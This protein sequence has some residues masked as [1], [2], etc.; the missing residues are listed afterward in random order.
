MRVFC[1]SCLFL[2]VVL[3]FASCMSPAEK[4]EKALHDAFLPI[5]FTDIHLVNTE[6]NTFEGTM[7]FVATESNIENILKLYDENKEAFALYELL[8]DGSDKVI[9]EFVFNLGIFFDPDIPI[10]FWDS[11]KDMGDTLDCEVCIVY[12]GR[13][14][15]FRKLK[16]NTDIYTMRWLFGEHNED[17][18]DTHHASNFDKPLYEHTLD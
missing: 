17:N 10:K 16:M 14:I 8:P 13:S 1:K 3:V 2:F 9:A 6:G 12:D 15:I 11:E 4:A 7:K 5:E 18:N